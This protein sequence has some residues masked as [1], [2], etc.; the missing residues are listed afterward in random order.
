MQ[1]AKAAGL[2]LELSFSPLALS[3]RGKRPI[4]GDHTR[5]PP[6]FVRNDLAVIRPT[7]ALG[8]SAGPSRRALRASSGGWREGIT[9]RASSEGRR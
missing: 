6:Y 2:L 9:E 3:S 7:Q 4:N 8:I 5:S 1:A